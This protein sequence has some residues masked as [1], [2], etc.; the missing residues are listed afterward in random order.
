ML[1]PYLEFFLIY[2]IFFHF[3]L[4]RLFT[5]H[6][7]KEGFRQK[8]I[9]RFNLNFRLKYSKKSFFFNFQYNWLWKNKFIWRLNKTKRSFK[10]LWKIEFAITVLLSYYIM[11]LVTRNWIIGH[12]NFRFF[13]LLFINSLSENAITAFTKGFFEMNGLFKRNAKFLSLKKS[14]F[15]LPFNKKTYF[16]LPFLATIGF[17]L[18]RRS[19]N[20]PI[21]LLKTFLPKLK[22][23]FQHLMSFHK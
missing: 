10:M 5:S 7:I 13:I 14:I 11:E 9:P 4:F 23:L 20:H 6:S 1:G 8:S 3:I 19:K 2:S 18:D 22:Y 21:Q 17:N 15:F 16:Y 12:L